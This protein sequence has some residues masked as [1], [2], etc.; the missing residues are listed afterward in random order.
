MCTYIL[1]KDTFK[2]INF[3]YTHIL[4]INSK[5]FKKQGYPSQVNNTNL[6]DINNINLKSNLVREGQII[7]NQ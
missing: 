7:P 1:F 6:K 3:I 4:D 5:L 2:Y